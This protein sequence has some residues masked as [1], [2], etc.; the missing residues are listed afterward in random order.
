IIFVGALEHGTNNLASYSQK[1]G[2]SLQNDYL[3]AHDRIFV[4]DG[5]RGTSF[6]APRVSG[7][8]ALIRHK[9]PNLDG[10]ALKQVL[11]QTATDLGATGV[12][13]VFGHG[14]LNIMN[15]LSPV[16]KVVAR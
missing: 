5:I 13:D 10:P 15:A 8:A 7:A 12:D 14:R 2:S 4:A 9:F 6:A 1:A 16:G 11:L 3:V